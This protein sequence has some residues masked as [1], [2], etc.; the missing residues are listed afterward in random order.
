MYRLCNRKIF[1]GK[2]FGGRVLGGKM[3][4]A[5]TDIFTIKNIMIVRDLYGVSL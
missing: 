3:V 1:L 5:E 4:I 2:L